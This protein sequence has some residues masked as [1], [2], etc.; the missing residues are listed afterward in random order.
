[1]EFD[2]PHLGQPYE[3]VPTDILPIKTTLTPNDQD[4]VASA[5]R[6]A[7]E[8]GTPVYP[9]GGGTSLDF[10]LPPN[11]EGRGLSLATV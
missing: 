5:V 11:A 3:R 10:G 1:M 9:M 8:T 6:E 2:P 7:F 4:A